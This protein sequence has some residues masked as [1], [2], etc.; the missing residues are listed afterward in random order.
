MSSMTFSR[1]WGVLP[2]TMN[3]NQMVGLVNNLSLL[4]V[5]H[6]CAFLRVDDA[7]PTS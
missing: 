5:L 4:A 3:C 6:K 2:H 7:L 1:I